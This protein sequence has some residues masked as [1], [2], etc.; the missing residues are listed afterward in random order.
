MGIVLLGGIAEP[1][2]PQVEPLLALF[3]NRKGQES[4]AVKLVK[5]TNALRGV[6]PT[7]CL[8][9]LCKRG[10]VLSVRIT[11][12]LGFIADPDGLNTGAFMDI[13]IP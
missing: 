7:F 9:V 12:C 6:L 2:P 11:D 4:N 3:L 1:P 5:C 8:D 13:R 10:F